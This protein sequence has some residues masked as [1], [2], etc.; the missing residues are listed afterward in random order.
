MSIRPSIPRRNRIPVADALPELIQHLD[1]GQAQTARRHALATL[2][3]LSPGQWRPGPELAARPGDIGLLIVDG[4][5]TRDVLLGQTV[6]TELVGHGDLLR[7]GDHDGSSA[8]VPFDVEW[9]VLQPTRIALLDRDFA[10][11][12]GRWP[13]AVELIVSNAVRRAQSLGLHL[14]ISHLRRVDARLLMLM[15]HMADRWGKVGLDGVSVPLNLT[16]QTLGSLVGARRPSVTT[17]LNQ[18][19]DERRISRCDDG[20]WLLHG[21]PP[22]ILERIRSN[23]D[24]RDDEATA[25][26]PSA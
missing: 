21:D 26:E 11:V 4:L 8:P 17:A 7:P 25:V 1:E 5:M 13:E 12:V 23:L 6:A 22:D 18:L 24:D 19:I 2:D 3:T 16:H 14:A 15:W 10:V 9:R 20:T